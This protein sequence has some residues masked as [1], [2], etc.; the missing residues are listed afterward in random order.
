MHIRATDRSILPVVLM[1]FLILGQSAYW[2]GSSKWLAHA[3]DHERAEAA[4]APGEQQHRVSHHDTFPASGAATDVEHNLLHEME[5]VQLVPSSVAPPR[6]PHA[7][8][9]AVFVT[10]FSARRGPERRFR[11][12][13]LVV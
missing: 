8:L 5:H 12:P 4:S 13:R 11:P 1:L 2:A 6:L 10:V 7:V 3:L 9:L